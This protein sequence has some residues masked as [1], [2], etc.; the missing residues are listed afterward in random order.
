MSEPCKI[1]FSKEIHRYVGVDVNPRFFCG[2][3]IKVKYRDYRLYDDKERAAVGFIERSW[4]RFL[5][6]RSLAR[7]AISYYNGTKIQQSRDS[8]GN[9]TMLPIELQSM[10]LECLTLADIV[11]ILSI[12]LARKFIKR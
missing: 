12:V 5:T 2:S 7:L 4:I 10:V 9:F 6:R 1:S 3:R 8:L 11:S